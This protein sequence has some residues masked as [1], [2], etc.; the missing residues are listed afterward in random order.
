M[1]DLCT[2]HARRTNAGERVWS[3]NAS[4]QSAGVWFTVVNVHLTPPACE[5]ALT[6]THIFTAAHRKAPISHTG[7]TVYTL[8]GAHRHL[9][10]TNPKFLLHCYIY[11]GFTEVSLSPSGGQKPIMAL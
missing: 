4:S 8:T 6:D 11:I 1:S 9:K 10:K 2:S 7:G 3:V 5:S